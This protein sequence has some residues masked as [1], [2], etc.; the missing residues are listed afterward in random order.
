M[1]SKI[2]RCVSAGLSI[3]II[4]MI[5]SY[6]IY[7]ILFAKWMDTISFARPDNSPFF[8][9]GLP[10]TA[11]YYG[12]MISVCYAIF[13]KGIPGERVKKGLCFALVLW[14]ATSVNREFFEY[15]IYP[16]PFMST[17]AAL[18]QGFSLHLF[19]GV[20]LPVVYG[21]SLDKDIEDT[22]D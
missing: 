14:M 10:C 15:F 8:L 4:D 16:V 6:L 20:L 2:T 22:R 12:L 13:Y 7:V 5:I 3:G 19:A 17:V 1:R 11:I 18:V 9:F 21:K